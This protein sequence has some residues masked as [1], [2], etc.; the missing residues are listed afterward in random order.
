M[1]QYSDLIMNMMDF[2]RFDVQRIQHFLKVY[3]FACLIGTGEEIS[4]RMMHILSIAAITHDIGIKPSEEKYGDCT[5]EHQEQ[6]G[7]APAREM[8][9][10]LGYEEDIINRV[11]YLIAHH[12]TYHDIDGMDYQILIEADFLVNMHEGNMDIETCRSI[13]ERI[14]RTTTGK[15][16]CRRMYPVR[17]K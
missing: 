7:P 10:K 6:E 17:E 15:R 9:T 5:G 16:I 11:C 1:E 14:F 3:E 4:E 12:H 2:D 13:Y 8:L